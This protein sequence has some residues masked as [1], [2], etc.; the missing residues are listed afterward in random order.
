MEK[1]F[2]FRN[3][4]LAVM[5]L[6]LCTVNTFASDNLIYSQVVINVEK[7]GTLSTLINDADKFRI[8][9]LKLSG[10]LNAMD[11]KFIRQ[12]AGSDYVSSK[13]QTT[14]GN[15]E[16]LD[17]SDVSLQKGYEYYG[18]GRI[19]NDNEVGFSMFSKCSL[20]SIILPKNVTK[21]GAY[22]FDGCSK[23]QSVTI[24]D[25]V[26]YIDHDSFFNCS[27]LESI[28]I[29]SSV[30]TLGE[31]AFS[32]CVKLETVKL[33][34][35]LQELSDGIFA[36]CKS[37]NNIAIPATVKSIGSRC[38]GECTKLKAVYI[39]D[40]TNWFSISFAATDANPLNAGAKLY[41]D[42]KEVKELVVPARMNIK[43][44]A[45]FGCTSLETVVIPNTVDSIREH[46]FSG[47]INLKTIKCLNNVPPVIASAYG[48]WAAWTSI[49]EDATSDSKITLYVPSGCKEAFQNCKVWKEMTINEGYQGEYHLSDANS[50]LPVGIYPAGELDYTR[51]KMTSGTYESFCLPFDVNTNELLTAFDDVYVPN[52]MALCQEGGNLL[53]TLKSIRG[54]IPAGQSFIAKVKDKVTSVTFTSKNLVNN[55]TEIMPNPNIVY[56]QTY[57]WDG[58]SGILV[59]NSKTK[60]GIAGIYSSADDSDSE[61]EI[62]RNNGCFELVESDNDL[63]YRVYVTKANDYTKSLVKQISFGVEDD[64]VNGIKQLLISEDGQHD[65]V[66]SVDG[67]L[68]NTTGALEGLPIGVYIKNHKK[69]LVK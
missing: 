46:S 68:I 6:L 67:R 4:L 44:N 37:L 41:L 3:H 13:Y 66:Y 69:I 50:T 57:D 38:F 33:P 28:I 34:N 25:G 19:E 1:Y 45:F 14:D 8:T 26:S 53:L 5:F 18:N 10:V 49:T 16:E 48:N 63:P 42:D 22:A 59:A 55:K 23:L 52:D 35:N 9:K 29:P 7:A 2:T 40:L 60:I 56:P 17:M 61:Y 43:K 51:D 24:Y 36:S 58:K 39:S 54:K 32:N 31:Y 20:V 30:E 65:P 21:I 12:M 62:F 27:S 47:C 15:L 64:V 11:I